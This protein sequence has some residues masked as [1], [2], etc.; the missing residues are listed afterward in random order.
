[1]HC[2]LRKSIINWQNHFTQTNDRRIARLCIIYRIIVKSKPVITRGRG[3]NYCI[4]YNYSDRL[5]A[6]IVADM[7]HL[8]SR[9]LCARDRS[10]N[11]GA[12]SFLVF[13]FIY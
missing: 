2:S 1:M 3:C 13:A 7:Y 6:D 4:L 5:A 9:G 10:E 8:I 11:S 12:N